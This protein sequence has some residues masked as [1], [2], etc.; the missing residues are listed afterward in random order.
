MNR[1]L[2][3]FPSLIT[4]PNSIRAVIRTG[5]YGRRPRNGTIQ[6]AFLLVPPSLRR[7]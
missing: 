3:V 6:R 5:G 7:G 2:S 1:T 4:L